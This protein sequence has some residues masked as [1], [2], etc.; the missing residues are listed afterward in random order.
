MGFPFLMIARPSFLTSNR[1]ILLVVGF[2]ASLAISARALLHPG[3][4]VRALFSTVGLVVVVVGLVSFAWGVLQK[5]RADRLL[6]A[7]TL[8]TGAINGMALSGG[9]PHGQVSVQGAVVCDQPLYSP[10]SNRPC[11]YYRVRQTLEW[12]HVQGRTA[13]SR[14][15]DDRCFAAPFA[16]D[17]GS[18]RAWVDA[19]TGGDF[20]PLQKS[21]SRTTNPDGTVLRIEEEILPLTR[22]LFV[23]GKISDA[24]VLEQNASGPPM[25]FL[26]IGAPS[27]S[28][29]LI[30]SSRSRAHLLRETSKSAKLALVA[31]FAASVLGCT[32]A[33]TGAPFES[34]EPAAAPAALAAP[35]V[36]AAPAES[37]FEE[38]PLPVNTAVAL[39]PPPTTGVAPSPLPPPAAVKRSSAPAA[40]GR[41]GASAHR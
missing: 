15:L 19:R 7:T 10:V 22:S 29:Q 37:S 27:P 33:T 41:R 36:V 5:R 9:R 13:R 35:A 2:I 11:L 20:E 14:L 4:E 25:P 6:D 24:C 30:V 16:I 26:A 1:P 28:N 17:D 34:S 3:S 40:H 21:E 31:S 32:L 38:A 8:S 18:G 39:P 23:C 12:G